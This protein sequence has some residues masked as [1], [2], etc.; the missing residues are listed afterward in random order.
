MYVNTPEALPAFEQLCEVATSCA[1]DVEFMRRRTYRPIVALIQLYIN[2]QYTILFDPLALDAPPAFIKMLKNPNCVK[3]FHACPQDLEALYL[4]YDFFPENIFDTQV[5]AAFCGMGYQM[6]LARFLNELLGIELVKGQQQSDWC[7][8]PLTES[9]LSYAQNEVIWLYDAYKKVEQKLIECHN[10]D[11]YHAYMQEY[12][13]Y[14]QNQIQQVEVPPYSIKGTGTFNAK[15]LTRAVHLAN[16]RLQQAMDHDL[17]INWVLKHDTLL[18]IAQSKIAGYEIWQTLHKQRQNYNKR[19]KEALEIELKELDQLDASEYIAP[20]KHVKPS[21]DEKKVLGKLMNL[22]GKIAKERSIA[23]EILA[24]RAKVMH[25]V[26]S[27]IHVPASLLDGW[28][29]ELLQDVFE[30]NLNK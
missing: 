25:L 12:T 7:K 13:S 6:G 10:L 16:W 22:I 5:A 26:Q 9:Q 20:I 19:V 8:R 15:S 18:F 24:P 23:A 28:R 4:K 17:P 29:A 27:G 3:V 30:E 11:F 2:N 14:F 1:I 21:D